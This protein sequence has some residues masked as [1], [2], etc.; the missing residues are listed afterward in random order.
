MPSRELTGMGARNRAAQLTQDT[1]CRQG[2][3]STM[4]VMVRKEGHSPIRSRCEQK[5]YMFSP[6]VFVI[7]VVVCLLVFLLFPL[8]I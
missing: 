4:E 3:F 5:A 2:V 8:S 1:K 6:R 7:A